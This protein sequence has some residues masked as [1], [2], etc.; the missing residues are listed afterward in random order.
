MLK[1]KSVLIT[2]AT[3]MILNPMM[4]N[5]ALADQ[6]TASTP[7]LNQNIHSL[8]AEQKMQLIKQIRAY[9]DQYNL[10]LSKVN[11]TIIDKELY[12]NI[13]NIGSSISGWL[14][15]IEAVQAYRGK[16]SA[17]NQNMAL[18]F[19]A[20]LLVSF[21]SLEV[22]ERTTRSSLMV[23]SEEKENLQKQL[24]D[25]SSKLEKLENSL[26]EIDQM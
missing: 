19:A 4:A 23:S 3:T 9:V 17:G 21:G 2:L 11:A 22:L 26:F 14:L 7:Q 25:L 24:S 12:Y 5:L 16:I 8:S 6:S 1:K 13:G 10:T 15:M 20:G 18:K